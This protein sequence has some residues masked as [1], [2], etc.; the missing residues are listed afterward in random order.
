MEKN[1][2]LG[3]IGAGFMSTAIVKGVLKSN[4]L[5]KNDI[6]VS[7]VKEEYLS[8]AKDLSVNTTTDNKYLADNSEFVLFAVKPQGA[9]NVFEQIKGCKCNKFISIM[10]GVKISKIKSNFEDSK[11][12]RCMPNTPCSLGVGAIGVDASD[13]ENDKDKEFIKNIL[14]S[15]GEVVFVDESKL[16]AVTGI[17]GSSPAYFYYFIRAL[18]NSG[19]KAGLEFEDAKKLAVSTMIGSGKMIL[20]NTDKSLDELIS[21]VCSKGGTTI[22]AI[23]KFDEHEL[24]GIVDD[25]VT[26]CINRAGELENL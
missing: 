7:D 15:C 10:A 17:S 12:A 25:A 5:S 22:E 6:I 8:K 9:S 3:V 2:K 19:V 26:A 4:I 16:N 21:A 14:S 11:V 1:F 13:F 23:K 20:E 18:I 24:N